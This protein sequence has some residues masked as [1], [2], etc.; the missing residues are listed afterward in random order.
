ME[1]WDD[2]W[3]ARSDKHGHP[4]DCHFDATTMIA[5]GGWG[6]H[7]FS[8][9]WFLWVTASMFGRLSL[10]RAS[11]REPDVLAPREKNPERIRTA[12]P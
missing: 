4:T 9:A 5:E 12:L 2:R 7:T 11:Q 8:S 1:R 10:G 6:R 3:C